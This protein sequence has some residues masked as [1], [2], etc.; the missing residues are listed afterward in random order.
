MKESTESG[1]SKLSCS[2]CFLV[3]T[4]I[5]RCYSSVQ[6]KCGQ[7]SGL[8][9]KRRNKDKKKD[10]VTNEELLNQVNSSCVESPMKSTEKHSNIASLEE[11][12][13]EVSSTTAWRKEVDNKGQVFYYN[14]NS[15][16]SR[17]TNPATASTRNNTLPEHWEI[18]FDETIQKSYYYN[19]KTGESTWRLSDTTS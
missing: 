18:I 19:S 14:V 13:A 4:S 11:N 15:K 6:N 8:E 2:V 10:N 12:D 5:Q 9:K 7:S 17:W 3:T 1:N 16:E